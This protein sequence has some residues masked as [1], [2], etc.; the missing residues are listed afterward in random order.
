MNNLVRKCRSN[1][2]NNV[3][4]T[5]FSL[6]GRSSEV[7]LPCADFTDKVAKVRSSCQDQDQMIPKLQAIQVCVSIVSVL[8]PTLG[9]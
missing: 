2:N 7:I 5:V 6:M 1:S 9:L 4:K 3:I 8:S